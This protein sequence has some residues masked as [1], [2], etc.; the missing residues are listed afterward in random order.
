MDESECYFFTDK[1]IVNRLSM[2]ELEQENFD[3]LI[4]FETFNMTYDWESV[5][6]YSNKAFRKK[7]TL[8]YT[9]ETKVSYKLGNLL[10]HFIKNFKKFLTA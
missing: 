9:L 7:L 10:H 5:S 3:K 6:H 1:L 2:I 8:G 4:Q